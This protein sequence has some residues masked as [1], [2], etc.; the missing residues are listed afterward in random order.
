MRENV[1]I[2]YLA[3]YVLI[4]LCTNLTIYLSIYDYQGVKLVKD[5]KLHLFIE[6]HQCT[7]DNGQWTLSNPTHLT[8]YLPDYMCVCRCGYLNSTLNPILY[9]LC[10]K[11][12]KIAFKRML[13]SSSSLDGDAALPGAQ[14]KIR[15]VNDI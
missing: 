12:F 11:N 10:N 14:R 8:I 6:Q 2:Y 5:I 3:I 13:R 7:M 15:K 1:N 9:P 4:Y